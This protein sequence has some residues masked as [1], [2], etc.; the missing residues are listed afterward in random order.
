MF[1]LYLSMPERPRIDP[2]V[3]KSPERGD[4]RIAQRLERVPDDM[5]VD[6]N[7][8][9]SELKDLVE[10]RE[11]ANRWMIEFAQAEPKVRDIL[12][13]P[14]SPDKH[15]EGPNVEDHYRSIL[16]A[17]ALLRDGKMP[18]ARAREVLGIEDAEQEWGEVEAVV[19]EH[20]QLLVAFAFM[21]DVAKPDTI[22]FMARDGSPAIEHGFANKAM[23]KEIE[24]RKGKAKD[25]AKKGDPSLKEAFDAEQD[26]RR[27]ELGA[28]YE[29]LFADFSSS[30]QGID[31]MDL[32]T[33]FF[34][35]YGISISYRGHAEEAYDGVNREVVERTADRLKL[36]DEER[37]LLRFSIEQHINPLMKFERVEGKDVHSFVEAAQALG[38]DPQKAIRALQ[39]GMLVDGII[40]TVKLPTRTETVGG[41]DVQVTDTSGEK[42]IYT[43]PLVNFW[44]AEQLYPAYQAEVKR[45]KKEEEA[46]RERNLMLKEERLDGDAL[47]DLG[48]PPGAEMGRILGMIAGAVRG[49]GTLPNVQ[50][51][52][53]RTELEARIERVKS[54]FSALSEG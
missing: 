2:E 19:K 51:A 12:Q 27:V 42:Y 6:V 14:Q 34:D 24:K 20:P 33:Q 22:G 36:T 18:Y 43:A 8:L 37:A 54:R 29:R 49:D 28:T 16:S 1:F 48:I 31:P 7:K 52:A 4:S 47:K 30:H 10:A 50:D 35:T 13:T 3:Y 46:A 11:E 39:A 45:K 9:F 44:K 25:A 26:A 17:V 5:R 40:G 23:D 32:Q 53:L 15:A 38:L 21:H 41:Q